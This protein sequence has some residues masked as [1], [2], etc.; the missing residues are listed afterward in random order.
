MDREIMA[1]SSLTWKRRRRTNGAFTLI[2][3]RRENTSQ[4]QKSGGVTVVKTFFAA[5]IVFYGDPG[6]HRGANR[7][8]PRKT[9]V[10]RLGASQNAKL[11]DWNGG[12]AN[13][14]G[15]QRLEP[16]KGRRRAAGV[17]VGGRTTKK[18]RKP[19]TRRGAGRNYTEEHLR[20]TRE[21]SLQL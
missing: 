13:A 19:T 3:T 17:M 7:M 8:Q 12:E 5:P 2:A 18:P 10:L 21:Y 14:R 9:K 1:I 15:S 20:G 16:S 11:I 6:V 4:G